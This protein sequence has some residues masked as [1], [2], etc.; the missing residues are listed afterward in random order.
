MAWQPGPNRLLQVPTE[1]RCCCSAAFGRQAPPLLLACNTALA[2]SSVGRDAADPAAGCCCCPASFKLCRS[3]ACQ[4]SCASHVKTLAQDELAQLSPGMRIERVTPLPPSQS[5][6]RSYG[7]QAVG[8]LL[9]SAP[10]EAPSGGSGDVAAG[11]A[12]PPPPASGELQ[13]QELTGI[14]EVLTL[15]ESGR[16][17]LER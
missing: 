8:R 12:S 3:V 2:D 7:Q 17:L 13:R 15:D 5:S 11:G 10:G 1:V 16:P 14:W 6:G 9:G 4:P